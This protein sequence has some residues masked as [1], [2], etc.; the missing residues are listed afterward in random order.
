ML[1][2]K[3]LNL[4]KIILKLSYLIKQ[5]QHGQVASEGIKRHLAGLKG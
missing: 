3:N 2:Y 1:S 4:P 5:F